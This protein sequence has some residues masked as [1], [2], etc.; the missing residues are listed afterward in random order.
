[1]WNQSSINGDAEN[2]GFELGYSKLRELARWF[3]GTK[4]SRPIRFKMVAIAAHLHNV[5][6]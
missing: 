4:S 2:F 6:N 5:C 3:R 1:M